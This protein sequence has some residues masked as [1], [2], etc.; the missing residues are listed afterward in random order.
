MSIWIS[1]SVWWAA[2]NPLRAWT[3]QK[4]KKGVEFT[5][6]LHLKSWA[7]TSISCLQTGNPTIGFPGSQAFRCGLHKTAGFRWVSSVQTADRGTS[8]SPKLLEPIP[9]TNIHVFPIC[10]VSRENLNSGSLSQL[11]RPTSGVDQARHKTKRMHGEGSIPEDSPCA[12]FMTILI[13]K[14]PFLF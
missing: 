5:P 10:S 7:E 12:F 8:Q 2:S 14:N 9:I 4:V 3:K 11:E 13:F 6:T 1:V